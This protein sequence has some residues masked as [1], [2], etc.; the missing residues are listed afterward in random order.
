MGVIMIEGSGVTSATTTEFNLIFT[1]DF[2]FVAQRA[3]K[4]ALHPRF[5]ARIELHWC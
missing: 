2:H 3:M 5:H 4:Y 1:R